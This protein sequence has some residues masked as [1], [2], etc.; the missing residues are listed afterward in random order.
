L[1]AVQLERRLELAWECWSRQD[2]IR[3][4]SFET[5]MWSASDCPR[6][7]SEHLR[8][9]P[10]PQAAW[11]TNQKLVQNPGYAAFSN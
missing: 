3:F 10:I 4:G 6:S 7:T 11:Q 9:Y 5:P 8:L 2:D 1:A